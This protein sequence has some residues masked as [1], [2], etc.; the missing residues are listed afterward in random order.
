[1]NTNHR[2]EVIVYSLALKFE[3][4]FDLDV[5]I[6]EITNHR[7]VSPEE[8]GIVGMVANGVQTGQVYKEQKPCDILKKHSKF[9]GSR[10]ILL[11]LRF[12]KIYQCKIFPIG[13]VLVSGVKE[14]RITDDILRILEDISGNRRCQIIPIDICLLFMSHRMECLDTTKE[15]LDLGKI[16][17]YVYQN[18]LGMQFITTY[19]PSIFSGL[20]IVTKDSEGKRTTLLLYPKGYCKIYGKSQTGIQFCLSELYQ[21]VFQDLQNFKKSV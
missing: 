21:K 7:I 2:L 10:I 12:D 11:F 8:Q 19:N 13:K 17:E 20:R 4:R 15:K 14:Y 16:R 1:M 9:G 3:E 5:L 6:E 18:N